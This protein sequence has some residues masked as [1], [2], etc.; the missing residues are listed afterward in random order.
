[1][2]GKVLLFLIIMI[3]KEGEGQTNHYYKK[4]IKFIN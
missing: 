1:M 3:K 2:A 4:L